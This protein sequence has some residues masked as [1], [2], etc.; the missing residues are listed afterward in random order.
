MLKRLFY[1]FGMIEVK[2]KLLF[3]HLEIILDAMSSVLSYNDLDLSYVLR[4]KK[5]E[6]EDDEDDVEDGDEEELHESTFAKQ[7]VYFLLMTS[8]NIG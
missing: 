3:Q 6:K 5:E 8:F 4:N 2:Q 7:F 1:R